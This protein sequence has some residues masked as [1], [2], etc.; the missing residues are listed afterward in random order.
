LVGENNLYINV[1]INTPNTQP[2]S[3]PT[4]DVVSTSS[5][6]NIPTQ[7]VS[8]PFILAT[9]V[10]SSSPH[11]KF[12]TLPSSTTNASH[13]LIVGNQSHS[14][15]HLATTDIKTVPASLPVGTQIQSMTYLPVS[16][17]QIP[18]AALQDNAFAQSTSLHTVNKPP[19]FTT[20]FAS[21]GQGHSQTFNPHAAAFHPSASLGFSTSV[22]TAGHTIPSSQ[23]SHTPVTL[24][25]A[26]PYPPMSSVL[27]ASGE[28]F[29][30]PNSDTIHTRR[31]SL[32]VF[33]G[34]RADWPEFKVVWRSLA[35]A[36]YKNPMQLAIE[37]KRCCPRG[38]AGES[39]KSI[40]VTREEA[41]GEMWRRLEEDY[42][43]P[44]LSVQSALNQLM[45]M[46]PVNEGDFRGLIKTVDTIES[47]HNQLKEL[48][49]INAI[50]M[51]DIDRISMKLP[52][53]V[54]M[55]WQRKYRDLSTHERAEPFGEFLAFLRRER[56]VVMRMA[57][58]SGQNE[59]RQ[60][61]KHEAD[62]HVTTGEKKAGNGD[63]AKRK[64]FCIIHGQGHTTEK[65]KVFKNMN[66]SERY[67]KLR[68]KHLCFNCFDNH[69]K[70]DC[71][72]PPCE[73]GKSHHYLLCTEKKD[74]INNS[75][76]Y[77]NPE[78]ED[79]T[80]IKTLGASIESTAI[81]PVCSVNLKGSKQPATTFIDG[82][83]NASFITNSY[84]EKH[85]LKR[86]KT[87]SLSISTLGDSK[88]KEKSSLYEVPIITKDRKVV[89][90]TAHSIP[91]ITNL[92][93]PLDKGTVQSL[94]PDFQIEG[95][96]CHSKEIDLL[97]GT[98]YFGL[99]PKTEIAKA[100]ENLSIMTGELGSCLVGSHPLLKSE[101]K[102]RNLLCR[103]DA[104][105]SGREAEPSEEYH[106][107]S[108]TMTELSLHK[109][110]MDLNS[111]EEK[112]SFKESST[113]TIKCNKDEVGT[114]VYD[115]ASVKGERDNFELF[116]RQV[117]DIY[118]QE[119][120]HS[121]LKQ[122]DVIRQEVTNKQFE[123]TKQTRKVT[124]QITEKN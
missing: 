38:R 98:D 75:S 121:L 37:L 1:E 28:S 3:M 30:R 2:V 9:D 91:V 52:K 44:G 72:K 53:D 62:S 39:L 25:Y 24:P 123:E 107:I 106:S 49:Q 42:D 83:S 95:L 93:V 47:V 85:K 33:S 14:P 60:S 51:A 12:P 65:C 76:E 99:H 77:D 84:A 45:T 59:R 119:Q 78:D 35:E 74:N 63:V 17:S 108:C 80:S 36:Q 89:V 11:D 88:T 118:N 90:V 56:A 40:Y 68:E 55:N 109:S 87:E 66:I 101:N 41:Y 113:L 79:N 5:L 15:T 54:N 20:G 4:A 103:T 112:T 26:Q 92:T 22:I 114:L 94:F 102:V 29:L 43:D 115:N 110:E 13:S 73:C 8:E 82:G 122:T 111:E 50:H 67:D 27:G 96:V 100:G 81:H 21:L 31:P 70:K 105:S 97:L 34:N 104:N 116:K 86:I 6:D 19:S 58:S 71:R 46:R 69:S 117:N 10:M 16:S 124:Q 61:R 64:D 120:I 7:S 57:E 18:M 32:P 23:I 48:N